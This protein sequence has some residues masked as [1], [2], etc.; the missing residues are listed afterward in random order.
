MR[1][2][3][4]V[5]PWQVQSRGLLARHRPHAKFAARRRMDLNHQ[6]LAYY[7][8]ALPIELRRLPLQ[9]NYTPSILPPPIQAYGA[10]LGRSSL[11]ESP[12]RTSSAEFFNMLDFDSFRII[13]FFA[14]SRCLP[15]SPYGDQDADC[16]YLGAIIRSMSLGSGGVPCGTRRFSVSIR[17]SVLIGKLLKRLHTVSLCSLAASFIIVEWA[18]GFCTHG[19]G[20]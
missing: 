6:P 15:A 8:R 16:L 4:A 17:H 19:F 14:P 1:S 10:R 11:P 2:E 3:D 20:R 13:I 12:L 5:A 18:S 7:A 9:V